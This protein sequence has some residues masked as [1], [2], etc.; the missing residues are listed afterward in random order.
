MINILEELKSQAMVEVNGQDMFGVHVCTKELDAD[1]FAE[2]IIKDCI[3]TL[4]TI[5]ISYGCSETDA[6][7]VE[8]L[9]DAADI[10][11]IHFGVEHG[12]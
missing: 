12:K 8:G 5:T 1:L 7:Y 3:K 6:D 11:A 2:L 10:I 9:T 4:S